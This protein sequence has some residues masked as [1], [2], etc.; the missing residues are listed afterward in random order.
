M[1]YYIQ[2]WRDDRKKSYRQE[3]E[4]ISIIEAE[5]V[6][7]DIKQ[8]VQEIHDYSPL[9]DDDD[10][11]DEEI[12]GRLGIA[13]D[14]DLSCGPLDD[15]DSWLERARDPHAM[16]FWISESLDKGKMQVMAYDFDDARQH[17]DA[18]ADN[19]LVIIIEEE[20]E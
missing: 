10:K 13:T 20:G 6:L 14:G 4:V 19:G 18:I 7:A 2:W 16:P 8:Q 3:I 15:P 12:A 17:F 5:E 9:P 11:I 1:K